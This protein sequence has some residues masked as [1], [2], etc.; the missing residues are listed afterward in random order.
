[1]LVVRRIRNPGI[2]HRN[3]WLSRLCAD[4]KDC[5]REVALHAVQ[6]QPVN[7]LTVWCW[8]VCDFGCNNKGVRVARIRPARCKVKFWAQT[9]G[10]ILD[11]V[12]IAKTVYTKVLLDL[13]GQS[14]IKRVG[15]RVI[16]PDAIRVFLNLPELISAVEAAYVKQLGNGPGSP[17]QRLGY[18]DL[19]T[20]SHDLR[21]ISRARTGIVLISNAYR[22]IVW[23]SMWR[24]K[25]RLVAVEV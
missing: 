12:V 18:C 25:L 3:R 23:R 7:V 15:A 19:I 14:W 1:M 9:T 20:D 22:D 24:T 6:F 11:E 8:D 5:F 16:R 2:A 13:N 21:V 10:R 4:A 17:I